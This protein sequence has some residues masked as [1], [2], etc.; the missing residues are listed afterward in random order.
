MP[1]PRP[2]DLQTVYDLEI[3]QE[4][5]LS[6][7]EGETVER[8]FQRL[9]LRTAKYASKDRYYR[10]K[11]EDN[12]IFI[13]RIKKEFRGKLCDFLKMKPGTQILLKTKPTDSD[14][15]KARNKAQYLGGYNFSTKRDR[16]GYYEAHKDRIGRLVI[17]CS[18]SAMGEYDEQLSDSWWN[19][20]MTQLWEGEWK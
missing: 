7:A 12:F 10:L 13:Q 19:W 8:A 11:I 3:D 4:C 6:P 2:D 15:T 16:K 5:R 9:K 17:I 18:M 20:P 14:V 1:F